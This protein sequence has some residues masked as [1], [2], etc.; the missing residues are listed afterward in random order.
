MFLSL[1]PQVWHEKTFI[2]WILSIIIWYWLFFL[3]FVIWIVSYIGWWW[4]VWEECMIINIR[5][6][7]LNAMIGNSQIVIK[8]V[9]Y[10][11]ITICQANNSKT[12]KNNIE[13]Y[14]A[15]LP[16]LIVMNIPN[17]F[18][19]FVIGRNTDEICIWYSGLK[20]F[21]H[22]QVYVHPHEISSHYSLVAIKKTNVSTA[23]LLAFGF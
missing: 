9:H 18:V 6:I 4:Y 23:K 13:S 10:C 22:P 14:I 19:K 2:V 12:M 20:N 7:F 3:T 15:P 8:F 21:P 17:W 16:W 5:Y 1:I 11:T